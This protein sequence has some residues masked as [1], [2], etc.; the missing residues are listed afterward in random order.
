MTTSTMRSSLRLRLGAKLGLAF[1][2]V[3]AVMLASLAVVAVAVTAVLAGALP[4]R[5][6]APVGT[7]LAGLGL[8]VY[9]YVALAVIA[10]LVAPRLG[11]PG[12]EDPRPRLL[13]A[14]A[15]ASLRI[16]LDDWL[17]CAGSLPSRVR[18]ALSSVRIE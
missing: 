7:V 4:T 11:D 1:T 17:L 8:L 2:G 12:P 13:G 10:A 14:L 18:T 15:M 16:A 9:F 3:L 6:L 5:L